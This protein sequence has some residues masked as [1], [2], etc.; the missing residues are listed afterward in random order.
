M[1]SAS[2][3]KS[4]L[5]IAAGILGAFYVVYLVVHFTG[6]VGGAESTGESLGAA[7]AGTLVAPH[8]VCS[9]LAAVFCILA[10][11]M[12]TRP[13]ALTGG[14]LF[15]VSIVLFPPYFFFVTLQVVFAFIGFSRLPAKP[16]D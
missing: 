3:K 11:C 4:N 15:A 1:P 14:I 2:H 16:H 8:G 10:W 9:G 6:A 13:F 7:L 12:N 5:L